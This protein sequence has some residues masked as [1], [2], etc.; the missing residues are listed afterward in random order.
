MRKYCRFTVEINGKPVHLKTCSPTD[1]EWAD[2]KAALRRRNGKR[3]GA[4]R[5]KTEPN[6]K[7]EAKKT[8]AYY[9]DS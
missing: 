1:E 4:F 3:L 6:K 9:G 8:G 7:R 2:I 5:P